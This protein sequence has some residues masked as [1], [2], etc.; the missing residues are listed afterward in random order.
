M[1]LMFFIQIVSRPPP[2]PEP[3][4][5]AISGLLV[6]EVE[7]GASKLDGT[8]KLINPRHDNQHPQLIKAPSPS[9]GTGGYPFMNRF[10]IVEGRR[11]VGAEGYCIKWGLGGGN[12]YS[13]RN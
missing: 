5:F 2:G 10:F 11:E 6:S 9:P 3:S 1:L 8:I 4:N 13:V 7:S 12:Y